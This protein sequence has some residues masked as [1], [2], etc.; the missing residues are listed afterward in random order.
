MISDE[1]KKF[2]SN[3]EKLAA[4]EERARRREAARAELEA[5][6][7]AEGEEEARSVNK[8]LLESEEEVDEITQII[9]KTEAENA[10]AARVAEA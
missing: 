10:E 1:D 8:D 2:L 9:N 3:L 6:P 4:K 7:P 5:N